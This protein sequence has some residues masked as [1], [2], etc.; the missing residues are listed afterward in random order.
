[1]NQT[2]QILHNQAIIMN[3]LQYIIQRGYGHNKHGDAIL[4]QLSNGILESVQEGGY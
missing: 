3:A 1:M 4:T 2:E